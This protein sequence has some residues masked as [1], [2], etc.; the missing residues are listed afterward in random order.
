MDKTYKSSAELKREAKALY[1]AIGAKQS[2]L[3][4]SQRSFQFSLLS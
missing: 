3:I 4:S 1:A 2:S